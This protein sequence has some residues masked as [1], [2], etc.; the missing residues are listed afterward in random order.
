M[1]HDGCNRV[2]LTKSITLCR[3]TRQTD[4]RKDKSMMNHCYHVSIP[5]V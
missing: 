3:I 5:V 2:A 4:E 1:Q